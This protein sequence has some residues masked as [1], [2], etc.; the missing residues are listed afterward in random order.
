MNP[1]ELNKVADLLNSYY[2][3]LVDGKTVGDAIEAL[4][5]ADKR[6]RIKSEIA[7]KSYDNTDIREEIL[8]V[9]SAHVV[10]VTWPI[11]SDGPDAMRE[12]EKK[13]NKFGFL[14]H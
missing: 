14:C 5:D 12:F 6:V 8:D 2:G 1:K 4:T 7:R 9:V 3:T 11:G 10:G 13:A